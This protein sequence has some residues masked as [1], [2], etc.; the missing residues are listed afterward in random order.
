M[1]CLPQVGILAI[2]LLGQHLGQHSY[3]EVQDMPSLWKHVSRSIWFNLC[4]D[5]FGV[6]YISSKYHLFSVLRTEKYEIVEDWAGNLYC[7][8]NLE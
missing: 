7:G 5:N 8:I 1:Y 4:I 3:F 6:K 2:K